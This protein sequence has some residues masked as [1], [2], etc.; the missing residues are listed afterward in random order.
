MRGNSTMLNLIQT[1]SM[2]YSEGNLVYINGKFFRDKV[3]VPPT[4]GDADQIKILQR[5]AREMELKESEHSV[6]GRVDQEEIVTYYPIVRF[7]CP[8]CN[9]KNK[10]DF[11]DETSEFDIDS[12]DVDEFECECYK[13]NTEFR[14]EQMEGSKTKILLKY[15]KED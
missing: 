8:N 6:E 2:F 13:C 9:T 1:N 15:Q 7:T 12:S 11:E 4:F 5:V 3:E 10:I 14:I